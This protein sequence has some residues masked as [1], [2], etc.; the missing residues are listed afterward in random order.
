VT[1]CSVC[2]PRAIAQTLT[3]AR[4]PCAGQMAEWGI[5]IVHKAC[6]SGPLHHSGHDS[7]VN[8]L[9]EV[10]EKPLS[11]MGD[12]DMNCPFSFRHEPG[13]MQPVQIA[14]GQYVSHGDR[15]RIRAAPLL[16]GRS[17][18]KVCPCRLAEP[19]HDHDHD[20][21]NRHNH[22]RIYSSG[23]LGQVDR[24]RERESSR[25]TKGS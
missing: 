17:G 21:S 24:E 5:S 18:R 6:A 3:G 10:E 19:D 2:N 25:S 14:K 7:L 1:T 22:N 13:F 8:V 12:E 16:F 20:H 23:A 4:V 9:L 15:Q 11:N